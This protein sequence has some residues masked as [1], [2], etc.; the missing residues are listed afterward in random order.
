MRNTIVQYFNNWHKYI[1]VLYNNNNIRRTHWW[2]TVKCKNR[3]NWRSP[4]DAPWEGPISC[5]RTDTVYCRSDR[6]RGTAAGTLDIV[7]K[8]SQTLENKLL[9]VDY[10]YRCR[11]IDSNAKRSLKNEPGDSH[12]KL[13]FD[14]NTTVTMTM[15]LAGRC[16]STARRRSAASTRCKAAC[17]PDS[18]TTPFVRR[19]TFATWSSRTAS[20]ALLSTALKKKTVLTHLTKSRE[21]VWISLYRAGLIAKRVMSTDA[22]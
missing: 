4:R 13:L 17:N 11:A 14:N 19:R 6:D 3:D 5:W 15:N 12:L 7:T 21:R 1:H 9:V 10:G 22:L 18:D 8:L 20:P 2:W 16:G